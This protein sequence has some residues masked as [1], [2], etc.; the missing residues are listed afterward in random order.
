MSNKVVY[1]LFLSVM[2]L[3]NSSRGAVSSCEGHLQSLLCLHVAEWS[4]RP[5]G[6]VLQPVGGLVEFSLL[7]QDSGHTTENQEDVVAA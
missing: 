1:D 2:Y 7:H 6:K 4:P 5:A 3:Y